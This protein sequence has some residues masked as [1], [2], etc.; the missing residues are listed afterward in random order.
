[1]CEPST[2][3]FADDDEWEL[4]KWLMKNVSQ[5]ATGEFLKMKGVRHSLSQISNFSPT[6]WSDPFSIPPKL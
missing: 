6:R 3:P 1:M 4:A 5:T 2:A